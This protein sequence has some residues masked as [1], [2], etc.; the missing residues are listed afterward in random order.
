[1]LTFFLSLS[2]G[3]EAYAQKQGQDRIDSLL[4][5]LPKGKGDTSKVN[6]LSEL[7]WEYLYIG[8][9]EMVEQY[10]SQ[11][12]MLAEKLNYK[13]GIANATFYVGK[14]YYGQ[15]KYYEALK[16]YLTAL[17][18]F[19]TLD[20]KKDL[21]V[22]NL[23]IGNIYFIIN[24]Y[25]EALKKNET[26]LQLYEELGDK[27]GIIRSY[28]GI[29]N[30]YF[31][32]EKD[33][34]RSLKIFLNQ[35]KIARELGDSVMVADAYA[36]IA[37]CYFAQHSYAEGV[38]A[39]LIQVKIFEELGYKANT[40]FA[41]SQ[42]GV[43]YL[44]YMKNYPKAL[45]CFLKSLKIAVEIDDRSQILRCYLNIGNTYGKQGKSNE[46]KRWYQKSLL[47]AKETRFTDNLQKAYKGLAESDSALG[48]Y[49]AAYE[50]YKLAMQYKD[51]IFNKE[52]AQKLAQAEM[53]SDFDKKEA[54]TNAEHIQ[55]ELR[56]KHELQRQK[57]MR[58]GFIAGF[59]VMLLFAGVFLWQRNK[60][61]EEKMRAER[62][63]KFKQQFL[64]NMS[65]EIRTPMNSIMGMTRLVLDTPLNKKQQSYLNS[66]IKAS[67]NLLHIINEILDLSKIEAGKMELE[68]IDFSV[69]DMV[70]HV[71]QTLQHKATEKNIELI[72]TVRSV[73][74]EVVIGDQV[75]LSQVLMNLVGNAIK[76]TEKGT[77]QLS[78]DEAQ[79]QLRFSITDT[80]IGIPQDKLQSIFE[81]FTQANL[82]DTRKYGGT[83]LGLSIS[84]QLVE[85]MGGKISIESEVGSGTTFS[86]SIDLPL[87]S[88][89]KLLEQHL[90][91]Q[92]D[93]S[94]LDGLSILLVDD[95]VDNR[96]VCRDTLESK[97]KVEIIEATNGKEAVE[98]FA[99]HD[100]DVV[101]MDVQ[102]PVMNGYEA[103]RQ[104][105]NNFALPKKNV[106][107]IALTASVI[108][109]DLD[110]CRMAG[111]DDY[112]P[113]PF[114]AVQLFTAI[115][116]LTKRDIKFTKNKESFRNTEETAA[117][118]HVD[119]S[120]L[121]DFCEGDTAKM[122]KYIRIFLDSAPVFISNLNVALAEFDAKEIASQVH[123]F[124]TKFIMM[125][126]EGARVLGAQLETD[127]RTESLEQAGIHKN[128]T[129]LIKMVMSAETELK[130]RYI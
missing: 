51:S 72:T 55:K 54:A 86:F 63:E 82:S 13:Y 97:S 60:I 67:E 34:L 112:V 4:T 31:F 105:R 36:G 48:N 9:Y 73:V 108:R 64:A 103:T 10:S 52:N 119:L 39:F 121:Q 123:G 49:K 62:S 106:P 26:A 127:C 33:Y 45:D 75:R 11:A 24:K 77:V 2:L 22:V 74:P 47:L 29:G 41:Y 113:K 94:I 30:V 65:H 42:L 21:A 69:R 17:S 5:E 129:I 6:L 101:L 12:Q 3:N 80:G 79:G 98:I 83:G 43:G 71:K 35:L 128:T 104:I 14:A 118:Q 91:D 68:Q 92:I 120:Y 8:S 88:K 57:I 40:A 38:S 130:I 95:N 78:V 115:A 61:K 15:H 93:G 20:S 23:N 81:S 32:Y 56:A 109:S 111:M 76:F 66:I 7:C 110:K 126:M 96:I 85:I 84:K 19:E 44:E 99:Q 37:S 53:Q 89:E 16:K 116:T 27:R 1:M 87:G 25:S 117:S 102:M 28:T 18:L 70:E 59:S 100:F 124:K 58:N 50:N 122:Q 125:G 46:S 90:S 114:K 107:V